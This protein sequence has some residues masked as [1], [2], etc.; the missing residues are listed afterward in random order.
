M[1]KSIL[2]DKVGVLKSEIH[3]IYHSTRKF[4]QE[5]TKDRESFKS[6]FGELFKKIRDNMPKKS[7]N[8]DNA[9]EKSEFEKA[10]DKEN[11]PSRK[12]EME[13]KR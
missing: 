13:M 1:D 7:K 2:Q 5:N 3:Q 12:Q 4:L 11:Q 6:V 9:I 8:V 10:H